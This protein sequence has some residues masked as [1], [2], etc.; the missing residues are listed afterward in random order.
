MS[1]VE[2]SNTF[3]FHNTAKHSTQHIAEGED[4]AVDVCG[5]G[6]THKRG[7][8]RRKRLRFHPIV[9]HLTCVCFNPRHFKLY[10]AYL[11][12][13]VCTVRPPTPPQAYQ[14]KNDTCSPSDRLQSKRFERCGPSTKGIR[15]T[16]IKMALVILH[17]LN[18]GHIHGLEEVIVL[19]FGK[20][21]EL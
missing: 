6:R 3:E 13:Y 16:R 14:D 5:Q 1:S 12:A 17:M 11:P 15:H 8:E 21:L 20:V 9:S 4:S 19:T 7:Q 18:L 10:K 2:Q